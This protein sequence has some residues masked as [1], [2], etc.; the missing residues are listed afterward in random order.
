M[1]QQDPGGAGWGVTATLLEGEIQRAESQ[2]VRVYRPRGREQ[3]AIG[4]LLVKPEEPT[5]GLVLYPNRRLAEGEYLLASM[6]GAR[7]WPV[8]LRRLAD[9]PNSSA[10]AVSR[11]VPTPASPG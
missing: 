9:R 3:L 4:R 10:L 6:S 8:V 7:Q 11:L 5:G 1:A 2:F